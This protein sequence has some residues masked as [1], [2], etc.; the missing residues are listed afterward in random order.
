[1]DNIYQDSKEEIL[2]RKSE[3]ADAV[4][5]VSPVAEEDCWKKRRMFNAYK[6]LN[7]A[8]KLNQWDQ[9]DDV[10]DSAEDTKTAASPSQNKEDPQAEAGDN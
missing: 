6:R 7:M 5:P 3:I 2:R 1:M 4:Q 8:Y 9:T 10:T